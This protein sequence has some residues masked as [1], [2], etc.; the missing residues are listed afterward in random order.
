M[1]RPN[2]LELL[3]FFSEAL[4]EKDVLENPVLKPGDTVIMDNCGFHHARHVEPALTNML[5]QNECTLLFQ[6]PYHS[7]CNTCEYCF[8][9]L[10]GGFKKTLSLTKIT[11]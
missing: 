6:P 9:G 5:A 11:L 3:N 7:V 8:R 2:G 1:D 10:K 4:E